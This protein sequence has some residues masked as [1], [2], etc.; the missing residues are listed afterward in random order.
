MAKEPKQHDE[1]PSV[2]VDHAFRPRNQWWSLCKICGL[3]RAAHNSSVPEVYAA[4]AERLRSYRRKSPDEVM[5]RERNRIHP[6]G[7][8]QLASYVGDDD[9]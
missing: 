2:I 5:R 6:G 8:K 1:A 7:R 4:D 9:D 3:A